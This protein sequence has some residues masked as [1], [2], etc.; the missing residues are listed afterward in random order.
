MFLEAPSPNHTALPETSIFAL[1]YSFGSFAGSY[2]IGYFAVQQALQVVP[3]S[4]PIAASIPS[5]ER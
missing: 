5:S 3:A 4:N 1:D 2:R